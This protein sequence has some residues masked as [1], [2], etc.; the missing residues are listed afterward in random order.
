MDNFRDPYGTGGGSEHPTSMARAG[1]EAG[2]LIGAALAANAVT[3]LLSEL[4]APVPLVTAMLATLAFAGVWLGLSGHFS[5]GA[6]SLRFGLREHLY[7]A[8]LTMLG[9]FLG[10]WLLAAVVGDGRTFYCE[11]AVPWR[12][13][14]RCSEV[15]RSHFVRGWRML[16]VVRD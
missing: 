14:L 6:S 9:V 4:V 3:L 12:M 11:P 13:R 8:G 1:H 15:S 2:T 16:E 10:T 7:A 5:A